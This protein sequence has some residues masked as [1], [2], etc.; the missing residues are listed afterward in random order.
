LPKKDLDK[1]LENNLTK[2]NRS[3]TLKNKKSMENDE[4]DKVDYDLLRQSPETIQRKIEEEINKD[5]NSDKKIHFNEINCKKPFEPLDF[6][7]M[8]DDID[9]LSE[10]ESGSECDVADEERKQCDFEIK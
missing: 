3:K 1:L 6:K 7:P 9:P 10:D 8:C 2:E 4:E 5:L